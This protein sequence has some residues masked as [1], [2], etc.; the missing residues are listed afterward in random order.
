MRRS[1]YEANKGTA[2]S[3]KSLEASR[4]K[5]S[6]TPYWVLSPIEIL[7]FYVGSLKRQLKFSRHRY[8]D[9]IQTGNRDM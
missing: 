2:P 4:R 9:C 7:L 3:E 8:F 6:V 5:N 1:K